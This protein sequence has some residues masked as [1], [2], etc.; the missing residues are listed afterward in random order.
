MRV[1]W[2]RVVCLLVQNV[3]PTT[4]RHPKT[5]SIYT[6]VIKPLTHT[7]KLSMDTHTHIHTRILETMSA[8]KSYVLIE[9][10][11][12]VRGEPARKYRSQPT[13]TIVHYRRVRVVSLRPTRAD[14]A[15]RQQ[16]RASDDPRNASG[17]EV[18]GTDDGN[19]RLI[20]NMAGNLYPATTA[21]SGVQNVSFDAITARKR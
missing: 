13:T 10:V 7:Y 1:A 5:P 20:N 4:R 6:S 2:Q 12:S 19:T 8:Q 16:R 17:E 15:R 11:S 9:T 14:D 21:P 18:Q 3:P